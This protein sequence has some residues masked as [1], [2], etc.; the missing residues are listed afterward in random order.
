MSQLHNVTF[1]KLE[2]Q[3]PSP[4]AGSLSPWHEH[5][6]ICNSNTFLR[7]FQFLLLQREIKPTCIKKKAHE[8]VREA[9]ID[10]NGAEAH[11]WQRKREKEENVFQINCMFLHF[12]LILLLLLLYN[13]Y[14][15]T[16]HKRWVCWGIELDVEGIL[17]TSL[18]FF[19][20]KNYNI[21]RHIH[22]FI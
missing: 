3:S 17:I 18:H 19:H 20:V 16:T 1:R 12:L 13:S 8:Y 9:K 5:R 4:L 15:S 6:L 11:G 21:L 14:T 22:N 2:T 10:F 7:F